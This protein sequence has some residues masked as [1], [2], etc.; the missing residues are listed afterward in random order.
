MLAQ[1]F[2]AGI[3]TRLQM[4]GVN[5]IEHRAD[6]IVSGNACH[7]EQ[8]VAVRTP[9]AIVEGTLMAEEGL[10]LHEEQRERGEP[11]VRH[12]IDR[13]TAL[14]LVGKPRAS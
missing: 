13:F 12:R 4:R 2:E 3:E 10:A 6:V 11:D 9:A 7:A 14:A 8:R 5:R 1:R